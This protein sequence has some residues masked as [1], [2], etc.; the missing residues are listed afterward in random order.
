MK[1]KRFGGLLLGGMALFMFFPVLFALAGSL[2]GRRELEELL[3]PVIAGGGG[4][5]AWR[6]FPLYPTL[7]SYVEV[8]MD[9]P[10]FFV[11]FWNSVKLTVGTLL[12]QLLVGAPAAWGFARYRFRGRNALFLLYLSLMLLPFQ[13]M[14]LS[15]YLVLDGFGLLDSLWG[16]VLPAVFSTYPVFMLCRFFEAVPEAL[17]E[18]A[19]MDGAGE[20][21]IFLK[22]GLPLGRPGMIS[23]LVL[24]FLEAWNQ[25]EQPMAFL[26]TKRFFPLSLY[27]PE[28]TM[29]Q[30]GKALAVSALTLLPALFVFL[31]G[32]DELEQ[33]II[34][35]AVKE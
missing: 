15:H 29:A 32:Q 23:A 24:G 14:M 34:S 21:Y 5:A 31:A 16:I 30:A 19:R 28:I 7:R 4:Y 22:I 13:V 27:L 8:L 2:M 26:K 17:L 33:G 1:A 9:S 3:S 6:F 10:E 11:M 18:A 25:I 20:F 12:G 35:T